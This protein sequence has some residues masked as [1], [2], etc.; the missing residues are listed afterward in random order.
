MTLEQENEIQIFSRLLLFQGDMITSKIFGVFADN[1]ITNRSEMFE[2]FWNFGF[3][4]A[5]DDMIIGTAETRV[6]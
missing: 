2:R 6:F 3:F 1:V 5:E 4:N